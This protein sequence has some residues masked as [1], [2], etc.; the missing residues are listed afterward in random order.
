MNMEIVIFCELRSETNTKV[1]NIHMVQCSI[2]LQ[3]NTSYL[4]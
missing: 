4:V 2:R 1:Y 3:Q